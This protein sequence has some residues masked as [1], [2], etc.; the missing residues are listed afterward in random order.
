MPLN[1]FVIID[2]MVRYRDFVE[3]YEYEDSF[4]MKVMIEDRNSKAYYKNKKGKKYS[5]DVK[6]FRDK[7]FRIKI[8]SNFKKVE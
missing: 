7:K 2:T 5:H 8:K 1:G 6:C 4:L 3:Q